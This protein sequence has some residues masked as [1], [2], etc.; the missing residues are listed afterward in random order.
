VSTA[1][2]EVLLEGGKLHATLPQ[3][4]CSA[5]SGKC[6]VQM[7]VGGVG[8]FGPF[9]QGIR[10]SFR[11]AFNPSINGKRAFPSLWWDAL[12]QE[13]EWIRSADCRSKRKDHSQFPNLFFTFTIPT[14]CRSSPCMQDAFCDAHLHPL[15]VLLQWCPTQAGYITVSRALC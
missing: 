1:T 12:L 8:S 3:F 4:P 6:E 9:P 5:K 7:C 2:W 14:N 13:R 11:N 10:K 15:M